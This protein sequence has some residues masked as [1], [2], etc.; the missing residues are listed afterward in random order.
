VAAY[1]L[2]LHDTTVAGF[3]VAE[4]LGELDLTNADDLEKR[5][6]SI[7]V[8][9]PGLVVDL[10]KVT[11]I[12]SAALHV[13]FR[14]G[15]ELQDAG[16]GYGVVL[17]PSAAVAKTVEMVHLEEAARI[18]PTIDEVLGSLQSS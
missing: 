14:I 2:E 13:L 8:E 5:L 9:A 15:R 16:K 4:V 6:E 1:E 17:D 11:F 12:D 10:N 18:G 7:V 3:A